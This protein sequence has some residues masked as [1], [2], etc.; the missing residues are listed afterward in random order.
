MAA[1]EPLSTSAIALR[2]V[3]RPAIRTGGTVAASLTMR[4][5]AL[6]ARQIRSPGL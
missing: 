1:R 2:A 6:E 5:A 3:P 4:R